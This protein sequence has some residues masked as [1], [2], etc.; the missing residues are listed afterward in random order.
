MSLNRRYLTQCCRISV[1]L[2]SSLFM[3]KIRNDHLYKIL[4]NISYSC[5]VFGLH[6]KEW[7][8]ENASGFDLGNAFAIVS[9]RPFLCYPHTL[10]ESKIWISVGHRSFGNVMPLVTVYVTYLWRF[11]PKVDEFQQ[12]SSPALDV[13]VAS[14]LL[15]TST[16]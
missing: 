5:T 8:H 9:F 4:L 7:G 12:A 6:K 14:F 10:T 13:S 15:L 2:D 16:S 3:G 11:F 1:A